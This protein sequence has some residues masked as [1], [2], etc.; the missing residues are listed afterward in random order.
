MAGFRLMTA[1]HGEL[2]QALNLTYAYIPMLALEW[3][4]LKLHAIYTYKNTDD[5]GSRNNL[6]PG[7]ESEMGEQYVGMK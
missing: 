4:F 2:G 5:Q 3:N 1:Q 7:F 6:T